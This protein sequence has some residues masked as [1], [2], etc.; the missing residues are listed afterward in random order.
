MEVARRIAGSIA[1][2]NPETDWNP[3]FTP[4]LMMLC[5]EEKKRAFELADKWTMGASLGK[6]TA[7]VPAHAGDVPAQRAGP[8]RLRHDRRPDQ[9]VVAADAHAPGLPP[10]AQIERRTDRRASRARW[11]H[12]ERDEAVMTL[13]L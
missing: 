13:P 8:D 6:L 3:D 5:P 4:Q 9:A 10:N 11:Q 2:I 12:D 1:T 7:V